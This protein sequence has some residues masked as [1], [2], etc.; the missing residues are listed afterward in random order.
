ML[1]D[2]EEQP[3]RGTKDRKRVPVVKYALVLK[4]VRCRFPAGS[5]REVSVILSVKNTLQ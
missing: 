5:P 4:A 2:R 3:A 1:P